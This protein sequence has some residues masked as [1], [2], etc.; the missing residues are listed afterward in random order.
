MRWSTFAGTHP[1][2]LLLGF[3]ASTTA[4]AITGHP[5]SAIADSAHLAARGVD[6]FWDQCNSWN[7]NNQT[8]VLS[9]NCRKGNGRQKSS[10][11]LN[12]CHFYHK[13]ENDPWE[14]KI[15]WNEKDENRQGIDNF[16]DFCR[17]EISD[18][19]GNPLSL[20]SGCYEPD[21]KPGAYKKKDWKK[22]G[23]WDLHMAGPAKDLGDHIKNNNGQLE[24]FGRKGE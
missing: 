18:V 10:L 1:S 2:L 17:S 19:E 7:F 24:C 15:D 16:C 9:G 8:C 4:V 5:S 13:V 6:P 14:W 21:G 3:V 23:G 20:W 11:N 22:V 12:K